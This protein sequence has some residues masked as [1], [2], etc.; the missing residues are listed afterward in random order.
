MGT[1]TGEPSALVRQFQTLSPIRAPHEFTALGS[2]MSRSLRTRRDVES[3]NP[4]SAEFRP[5]P[6]EIAARGAPVPVPIA[7]PAP[8]PA[9]LPAAAAGAPVPAL[10]PHAHA[11]APPEVAGVQ[12]TGADL[13]RIPDTDDARAQDYLRNW[14]AHFFSGVPT[15][16]EGVNT[17]PGPSPTLTLTGEANPAEIAK[18]KAGGRGQLEAEASR[19]ALE[20][21]QDFGENEHC[22][23]P[24][25]GDGGAADTG[26]RTPRRTTLPQG[27]ADR[28]VPL[29]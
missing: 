9:A 2:A 4:P 7:T 11:G 17:D 15:S 27:R 18:M 3:A 8:S 10:Q 16:D 14:R 13:D 21:D 25:T 20:R 6:T 24:R 12:E 22:P 1:A 26:R 29:R 23:G 28:A 19:Q 5:A